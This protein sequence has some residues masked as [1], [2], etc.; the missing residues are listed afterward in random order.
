MVAYRRWFHRVGGFDEFYRVW[1]AEDNDLVLRAEWDGVGAEWISGAVVYHQWHRRDWPTP[2]Q[3]EQVAINRE[4]LAA[5][6][7]AGGPIVRN[8]RP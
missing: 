7:R 4:Y 1:G 5:R 6:A 8:D 3:T 2:E